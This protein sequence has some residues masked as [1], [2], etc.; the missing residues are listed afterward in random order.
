MPPLGA[1]MSIAGGLHNAIAEGARYRCDAVQL[2][3][4]SSNQWA[5]RVLSPEDVDA[6]KDAADRQRR[7]LGRLEL[8]AHDSYLINLASPVPELRDRSRRAF[9]AELQRCEMLGIPRLVMHPG[10]HMGAGEG[11]GLQAIAR[12]LDWVLK[13]DAGGT[14]RILLET[15]AGQGTSLGYRF[16]HLAGI[17][18][19]VKKAH[20]LGICFDT[21]HVLAAGYE[22]RTAEGYAQTIAEL[23][24]IVGL[25]RLEWFHLNDSKRELG[26]RVD[27]HAHIGKGHV[28]SAA[29]R[30]ILQDERFGSIPMVLETPKTDNMDRRN[31]A[32]LRRLGRRRIPA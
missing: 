2:F 11:R 15:T 27:R 10:S 24:R 12:S 7:W 31:L 13:R 30:R 22:Y 6:F 14:T 21:C 17:I 26:S 32:L 8:A 1:H 23:E 5:A 25:A 16:E 9:L 20:R 19:R 28:G 3:T 18:S 4:K 29:F